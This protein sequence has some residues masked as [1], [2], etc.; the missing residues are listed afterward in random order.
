MS[1]R[2]MRAPSEWK[3]EMVTRLGLP[4]LSCVLR[5]SSCV[6][7]SFISRAALLVKVTAR[8][9]SARIPLSRIMCAMR[10]VITR[11][12]PVP[13]PARMSTGPSVVLTAR[14]CSGLSEVK[15]NIKRSVPG[16]AV[17]D[18][19]GFEAFTGDADGRLKQFAVLGAFGCKF[20]LELHDALLVG[21]EALM[22]RAFNFLQ[23]SLEFGNLQCRQSLG[24]D[25]GFVRAKES[26]QEVLFYPAGQFVQRALAHDR[27]GHRNLF[28]AR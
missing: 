6:T 9:F 27:H 5:P 2:K 8:M 22:D 10:Q 11:V 18:A 26:L 15:S 16:D 12:L 7:R 19:A 3:V 4:S 21:L 24:L 13:A 1:W 23:P 28:L 25:E 20:V 14:R 17:L